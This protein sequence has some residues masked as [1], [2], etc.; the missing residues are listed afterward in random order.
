[1]V[2]KNIS[3][4]HSIQN[5]E[6]SSFRRNL[7]LIICCVSVF[8]VGVDTSILNVALP[9]IQHDFHASI[10]EAQWTLDAYTLVIASLLV[11]SSSTAD[12]VGRRRIFQLGVSLF[13]LGSLLC[14]LAPS[15]TWLIVFRMMQAVGGSMLN[16]V[17]M[18]I[19]GNT[20]I[21]PAERARA[22][23][24]WG[25]VAGISLAAGPILGGLLVDSIGWR[26]I[27]WINVPFGIA[28]ILLTA[29]FVPESKAPHPRRFDPIGQIL[30]I[31]LLGLLI[32]GII[33]VPAY[34]W[35]SFE[36]LACLIGAAACF[37][38]FIAY[39][40]V[41]KEPLIDIRFFRSVPFSGASIIA[42]CTFTALGGFS[43][44]NT[45]Y[46]QDILHF[47]PL[48]AGT[49]FLPMAVALAISSPISG[50]IIGRYG[51]RISLL[52]GGAAI[53][54]AGLLAAIE[55]NNL[56]F[57]GLLVCYALVGSGVGWINAA[58]SNTALSGMPRSQAGA[59]AGIASTMRQLGQALGV[60]VIGSVIASRV[61]HLTASSG[62]TDA[63]R[64]SWGIIAGCGFAVLFLGLITTGTWAKCT[65]SRNA[66]R[67]QL[68]MEHI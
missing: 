38:G 4:A 28:V 37:V 10:A 43:I 17:A 40:R 30:V 52:I 45:L 36:I 1:M 48:Q 64:I 41:R 5:A 60:A 20:F 50:R 3:E 11:L 68:E 6:L 53:A 54:I 66:E 16:P 35:T 22:V 58:I 44:L 8:L 9:S 27:F 61:T 21:K 13:T 46:L 59:A 12:R 18:S 63:S 23:G 56:P 55:Y 32:Y 51:T 67:M 39:E 29:K 19:I 15:I 42:L 33:E 7:I 57:I 65:A 2:T 49:A 62:F 31:A 24:V 34:G 47:S 26:S 14:S 25:G